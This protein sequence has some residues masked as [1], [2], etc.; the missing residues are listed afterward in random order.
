MRLLALQTLHQGMHTENWAILKK[1][2]ADSGHTDIVEKV[3]FHKER[4][5]IDRRD[6]QVLIGVEHDS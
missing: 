1:A 2:L 5:R 6:F 4:Y 3:K